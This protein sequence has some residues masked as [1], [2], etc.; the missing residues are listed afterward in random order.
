[1]SA[2]RTLQRTLKTPPTGKAIPPPK[3]M[4]PI[5]KSVQSTEP[6]VVPVPQKPQSPPT[7]TQTPT[8]NP[9]DESNYAVTEL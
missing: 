9:N 6:I 2:I 3:I 4:D 5:L 1:M 7:V 8:T